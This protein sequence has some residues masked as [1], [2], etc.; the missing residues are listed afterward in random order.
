MRIDLLAKSEGGINR[1]RLRRNFAVDSALKL[2]DL[3]IESED[4]GRMGVTLGEIGSTPDAAIPFRAP[5][6]TGL[7]AII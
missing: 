5:Y 1:S 4:F 7:T 6:R 2:Q 3:T